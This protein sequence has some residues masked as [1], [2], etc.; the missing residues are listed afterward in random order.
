[1]SLW[2][3]G[4]PVCQDIGFC[5]DHP[6]MPDPSTQEPSETLL[7]CPFCFGPAVNVGDDYITCGAAWAPGCAGHMVRTDAETWN[8]R[9]TRPTGDAAELVER[10]HKALTLAEAEG[11]TPNIE[12]E[13]IDTAPALSNLLDLITRQ[14]EQI[15]RLEGAGKRLSLAAQTTGGTAGR[16]E[17]LVAAIDQM[18]AALKG[19][20][21]AR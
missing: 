4:C 2:Q 12:Q 10:F 13:L 7:P 11:F 8:T 14:Q 15:G 21:N 20:S 16:D 9:A 3:N 5:N 17:E 19:G 1:V 18:S 6:A